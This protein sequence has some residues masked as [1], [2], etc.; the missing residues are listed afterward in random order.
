MSESLARTLRTI[1]QVIASGGLTGIVTLASNGLT[2]I[3]AAIVFAV[4]QVGVTY[5]QNVLEERKVI[6]AVFKPATS[7]P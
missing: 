1:L 4:S 5:C 7:A 6:P 3:V 2:P